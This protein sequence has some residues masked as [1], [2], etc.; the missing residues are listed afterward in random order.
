[1]HFY[2]YYATNDF[3]GSWA[4]SSA[5]FLPGSVWVTATTTNASESPG[6]PGVFTVSRPDTATNGDLT[7]YYTF[8]GAATNGVDYTAAASN[9]TILAGYS[10]A[11]VTIAPILDMNPEPAK[12]VTLT[13]GPGLY[14]IGAPDHDTIWIQDSLVFTQTVV[15]TWT[16]SNNWNIATNWSPQGVPAQG[17]DVRISSGWVMLTNATP[18][19]YAFTLNSG[20][21]V[22]SNW[23]TCIAASNVTLNSGTVTHPANTDSNAPWTPNA[24]IR[25]ICCGLTMAANCTMNAVGKG[26][27]V[28]SNGGYGPGGGGDENIAGDH[29][30]GGGYGGPGGN[31]DTP[32]ARGV[33]GSMYG[34]ADAPTDPGSAGSYGQGAG[35]AGGGAV[36]I[37]AVGDVTI[38]GNINTSGVNGSPNQAGGGSGGAVFI[39]CRCFRGSGA[40][41][42]NAGNA[43]N[44][45]YPGGGGGGRIAVLCDANQQ[46]AVTPKPTV[47]FSAR[48]GTGL[49]NGGLGTLYLSSMELLARGTLTGGGRIIVPGLQQWTWTNDLVSTNSELVLPTGLSVTVSNDLILSG[50]SAILTLTNVALTVGRDVSVTGTA[51]ALWVHCDT[52]TFAVGR[53]FSADNGGKIYVCAGMSNG[54][55]PY[56]AALVNVGGDVTVGTNAYLCPCSQNTNGGSLKFAVRN[57]NVRAGGTVRAYGYILNTVTGSGYGPGGGKHSFGGSG[58]GSGAGHGGKGG[59]SDLVGGQPYGSSNAPVTCGS[60]G[61]YGTMGIGSMNGGGLVWIEA[62]GQIL[63]DGTIKADGD[64]A[65]S[66]TLHGGGGAGGGIHLR[67]RRLSGGGSLSAKGGSTLFNSGNLGGGGGGGRIAVWRSYD[68]WT[69]TPSPTNNGT[70]VDGGT[71]TANAARNGSAGTVFWGLVP[72][73]GTI[74]TVK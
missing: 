55:S 17:D 58:H 60:A 6:Y 12:D 43:P 33:G 53:N 41:L 59:D 15:K 51:S 26:Y 36:R 64:D 25:F 5:S 38:D 57:V 30:P 42:A 50:T 56:Y 62:S 29:G 66:S 35:G 71:N 47:N 19:L 40:I 54:L 72:M 39:N 70:A 73:S 4:D 52:N 18:A 31:S 2:R 13:L 46:L 8:S 23:D 74:L 7:V 48:R 69:G 68:S 1:M 24:R 22:F 49:Y 61:S 11:T 10:N 67:C 27:Q 20:T 44:T 37:D 32:D 28:G 14:V 63:V 3:G 21:L 65:P 16:G 9:V 34:T 45:G